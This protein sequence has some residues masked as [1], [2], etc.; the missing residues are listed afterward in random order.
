MRNGGDQALVLPTKEGLVFLSS[1]TEENEQSYWYLNSVDINGQRRCF[2]FGLGS[3]FSIN[4]D[5]KFTVHVYGDSGKMDV[6]H[7]QV[8]QDGSV[9]QL[10][11]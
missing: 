6:H 2:D 9:H 1:F 11:W 4:E 10:D 5:L 7:Y 8:G 3:I